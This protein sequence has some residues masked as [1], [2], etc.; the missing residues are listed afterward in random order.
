MFHQTK[1]K[2]KKK[3]SSAMSCARAL[4][5]NVRRFGLLIEPLVLNLSKFD[6]LVCDQRDLN[7]S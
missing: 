4:E 5:V 3:M 7:L 1:V 2:V 6:V